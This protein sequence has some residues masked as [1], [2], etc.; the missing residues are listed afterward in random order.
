[1]NICTQ[2]SVLEFVFS[3]PELSQLIVKVVLG[4]RVGY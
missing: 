1:M 2:I 4:K 3:K